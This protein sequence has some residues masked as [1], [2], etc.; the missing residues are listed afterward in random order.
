MSTST[1]PVPSAS[2]KL[3]RLVGDKAADF[4]GGLEEWAP[5]FAA[6]LGDA[7]PVEYFIEVATTAYLDPKNRLQQCDGMSVMRALFKAAQLKLRPDGREGAVIPRGGQADFEPMVQGIIRLM[8][9]TR[10]VKKVEARV[11]KRNDMFEYEYGLSPSLVHRPAPSQDQGGTDY[12]YA[13]VW[14]T[15]GETQFEVMDREQLETVR[16]L[17]QENNK[18]KLGPAWK[19]Y[20]DEMF[21]KVVVKRLAK[22]MEQDSELAAVISYD[23]AIQAGEWVDPRDVLPEIEDRTLQERAEAL[24]DSRAAELQQRMAEQNGEPV[25]DA[26]VVDAEIIEEEE[27][28]T[29]DSVLDFGAYEGRTIR[30]LLDA[31]GRE[32]GYVTHWFLTEKSGDK[33]TDD[34]RTELRQLVELY[35]EAAAHGV[36]EPEDDDEV[37]PPPELWGE[38]GS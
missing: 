6:A 12:V 3:A 31:G 30:S 18:G 16:R 26:T 33:L 25:E 14:L 35:D 27:G 7:I 23:N 32:R 11:V 38:E 21:R 2:Q 13:I 1:K 8:L 15:N 22:Y 34:E 19:N 28:Y 37:P 29:L 24:A 9:R 20:E 36:E 4:R 10:T 17:T 5:S